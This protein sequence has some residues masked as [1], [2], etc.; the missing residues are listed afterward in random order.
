MWDFEVQ[1]YRTLAPKVL[2]LVFNHVYM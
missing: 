2:M 1:M